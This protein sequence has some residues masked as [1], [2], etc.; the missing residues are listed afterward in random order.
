MAKISFIGLGAMGWPIAAHLARVGHDVTVYNR[1][2]VRAE[3]WVAEHGGRLAPTP[4]AAADG[5]D[6][7][8]SSVAADGDLEAVTMRAEGC[9]RTMQKGALFVDHSSVSARLARQLAT[10]GKDRGILVVDAPVTGAE[11]GA[12]N[13]TLSIMCGGSEKAVAAATPL[14]EAYAKRIVHVGGPGTGQQ[15]KM[16]NQIALAITNQAI[17]EAL[18]FAQH[19]G[20]DLEKVFEVISGGAASSW[21]ML[22]RWQSMSEQRFDFGFPAEWMRKDLGLAIEEA[23]SNGAAMPVAALVDQFYA[24]IL[25]MHGNRE[26]MSAL[27]RR[28]PPAKPD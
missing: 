17:A 12:R 7:V 6:A 11:I 25:S 18:H 2:T 19:V 15:T 24:E 5:A 20:L 3:K 27:I 21:L 1:T 16:V 23:R 10:E 8:F 9:F 14:M 13:G 28:L 22:N 4:A 26:D